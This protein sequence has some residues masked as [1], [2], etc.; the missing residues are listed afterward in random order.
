MEP[1]HLRRTISRPL[2][3]DR[4]FTLVELLVVLA[5]MLTI[6]SIALTSQSSFNKTLILAN[7]AYDIGLTLRSA[8]SFG[9]GSRA[10]TLGAANAGYG[11]H[12]SA[13]S[14]N[15]FILFADTSPA[16]SPGSLNCSSKSSV[17]APNCGPGDGVYTASDVST[18][19]IP[20]YTLNNGVIISDFCAYNGSWVCA[21]S[22]GSTLSA[23]DI[24]FARPNPT[25]TITA[26]GQT[27]T[28]ACIIVSS[29][30]AGT[31]PHYVSVSP[32]GEISSGQLSA[33]ITSCP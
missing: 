19:S 18:P 8:E 11:I 30:Q 2:T 13:G 22:Y 10:T 31:I 4:G 21:H 9:L 23:L 25:P 3:A 1:F 14:N 5:I 28:N 29:L 32:S 15:S 27:Y 17:G 6:T 16:G 20:S 24:V 12:I 33:S 26:N 7:T